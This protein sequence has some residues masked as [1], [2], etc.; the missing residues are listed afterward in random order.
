MSEAWGKTTCLQL[1][2]EAKDMKFMSH[3]G[4]QVMFWGPPS[5]NTC[6]GATGADAASCAHGQHK[7]SLCQVLWG[8]MDGA[9]HRSPAADRHTLSSLFAKERADA[10]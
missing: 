3:G 6:L 1:A 5:G 2:L 9:D 7:R 4:I 8:P 10:E